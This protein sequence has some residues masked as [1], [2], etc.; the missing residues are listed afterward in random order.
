LDPRDIDA[1][2]GKKTKYPLNAYHMIRMGDL[3]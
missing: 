1:L 2:L 3:E